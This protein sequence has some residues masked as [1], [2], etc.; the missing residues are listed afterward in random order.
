MSKNYCKLGFRHI[1]DQVVSKIG[2]LN[3]KI[4]EMQAKYKMNFEEFK[5]RVESRMEFES[6]KEWDDF[7]I[8]VS[9]ESA[10]RYW[11]DVEAGLKDNKA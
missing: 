1:L 6:F 10:R 5:K 2:P 4:S 11:A 9:F 7:I 3:T 8:L